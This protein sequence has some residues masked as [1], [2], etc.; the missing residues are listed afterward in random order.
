VGQDKNLAYLPPSFF[1]SITFGLSHALLQ[2]PWI[3]GTIAMMD[4]HLVT[5]AKS[6]PRQQRLSHW[7]K[8]L[9]DQS[10]DKGQQTTI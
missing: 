6:T 3:P 2:S 1:A 7:D 8:A 5:K 9:P 4:K 10:Y